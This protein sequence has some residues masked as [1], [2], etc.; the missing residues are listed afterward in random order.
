M[1]W[2]RRTNQRSIDNPEALEP[3]VRALDAAAHEVPPSPRADAIR[4]GL[5]EG[6]EAGSRVP[7]AWAGLALAAA[8]LVLA[9]L[10]GV[11]GPAIG[12]FIG[13]LLDRSAPSLPVPPDASPNPDDAI[14]RFDGAPDE[15]RTPVPSP[16]PSL[17]PAVPSPEAPAA[18]PSSAPE[19]P[20]D[21]PATPPGGPPDPLPTP[22][23]TGPP[24]WAPSP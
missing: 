15:R 6:L 24:D 16:L 11:G 2:L 4:T 12:S 7:G 5:L 18:G 22:P 23:R 21:P 17:R 20:A 10:I 19:P 3:I 9:I 8:V 13:D 1:N 14:D